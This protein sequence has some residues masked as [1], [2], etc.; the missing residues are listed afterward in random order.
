[1]V[2]RSSSLAKLSPADFQPADFPPCRVPGPAAGILLAHARCLPHERRTLDSYTRLG[3]AS[4][5]SPEYTQLRRRGH[6]YTVGSKV[7]LGTVSQKSLRLPSSGPHLLQGLQFQGK[8][9]L[10][11]WNRA[12]KEKR[13][14]TAIPESSRGPS[15]SGTPSARISGYC[16]P[17]LWQQPSADGKIPSEP[18][19]TTPSSPCCHAGG[20]H[21]LVARRRRTGPSARTAQTE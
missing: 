10:R 1:M 16:G 15:A 13:G 4:E 17:I 9:P 6:Y 12:E 21:V 8:V 3:P 2:S 18:R 7:T 14:R 5:P 20:L 11:N 19:T